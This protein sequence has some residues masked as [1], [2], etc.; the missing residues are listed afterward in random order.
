MLTR[1]YLASRAS[2]SL[3]KP[4]LYRASWPPWLVDVGPDADV[5]AGD[6][7]EGDDDDDTTSDAISCTR[8]YVRTVF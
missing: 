4:A 3:F 7:L 6:M 2:R 5:D 1:S 8:T